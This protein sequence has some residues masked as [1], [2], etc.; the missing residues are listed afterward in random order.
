MINLDAERAVIT[1]ILVKPKV[2]DD[3]IEILQPA[4]FTDISYGLIYNT[5]TALDPKDIDIISLAEKLSSKGVLDQVGGMPFLSDLFHGMATSA[6]AL[7]YARVLKDKSNLRSLGYKL[8]DALANLDSV[9]S[10]ADAVS[11]VGAILEST[12]IQVDGYKEFKDIVRG[13]MMNLDARFK[14][15][16][17]FDGLRTG[18]DSLDETIMGLKP[19]DYWVIGARPSMGKTAFSLAIC[20]NIAKAGGNVLYFSAESSK[21]SLTDRVIT[22][23]SGVDSKIIKSARLSDEN[24][25]S[26]A[27]GV[28]TIK[29]YSLNIIDISGIDIS[30]AKAIA[31][32]FNRKRKVDLIVVDYLQLMTCKNSKGD[33]EVTSSV[34]RGL[35][36]MAK[37]TGCPII[38]L[39]QLSREVEKRPNK[40][41][42][43]SD[44]R[45]TGQIEQDADIIT[46][47]YRD[48][49]YNEDSPDKGITELT[50]RKSRDGE[51]KD[52]FFKADFSTMRYEEINYTQEPK[53]P[54]YKPFAGK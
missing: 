45:S 52:H 25:S 6:N 37:D 14:A 26:L 46:F 40:R 21:E 35:K 28:S 49:Y 44:L 29:D 16:G 47:L 53:A 27:A 24:W 23:C 10:Y 1:S 11:N 18:F 31:R 20:Q 15:G 7:S 41:P 48:E 39:A 43:M 50:M 42:L 8:R 38:A 36:A 54:S 12:D 2:I 9:E 13:Q 34:S 22:S 5:L 32:K 51:L 19:A 3:I 30:H 33:F 17:G 4:D